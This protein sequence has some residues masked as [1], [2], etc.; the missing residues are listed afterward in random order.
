MRKLPAGFS[1]ITVH[2]IG[3]ALSPSN[4][5]VMGGCAPQQ[6]GANIGF[7]DSDFTTHSVYQHDPTSKPLNCLSVRPLETTW[8]LIVL[9]SRNKD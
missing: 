6:N 1:F 8:R 5:F 3:L 7:A 9:P 4:L 2:T